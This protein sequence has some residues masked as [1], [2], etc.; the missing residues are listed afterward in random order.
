MVT[1]TTGPEGVRQLH[2]VAPSGYTLA[3]VPESMSPPLEELDE[4]DT[5]EDD[6]EKPEDDPD[7]P[8][9]GLHPGWLVHALADSRPHGV[10]VPVQPVEPVDVQM[11]PVRIWQSDDVVSDGQAR[12][13]PLHVVGE[14]HA[15]PRTEA[16]VA[17]VYEL[18]GIVAPEQVPA[19]LDDQ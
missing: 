10:M 1:F 15:Q 8:E 4:V 7:E 17:C 18:H 5:P 2:T 19:V 14:L 16:Q 3:H 9:A 6:P 12:G 13:V 11:Q